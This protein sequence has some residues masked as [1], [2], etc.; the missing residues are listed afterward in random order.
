MQ[1]QPKRG[2]PRKEP[3]LQTESKGWLAIDKA[4]AFCDC[5]PITLRRAV[6]AGK[7]GVSRQGGCS[8]L[9]FRVSDLEAWML[10]AYVA[11]AHL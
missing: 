5:S 8:K 3:L 11:A 2:R 10:S 6:L 7:L 4:A 9:K 1:P